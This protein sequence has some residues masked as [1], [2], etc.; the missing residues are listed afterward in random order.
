MAISEKDI[1][2]LWGRAAGRCSAPN[3]GEDLTPLLVKSGDVVLGE[4][5]HVIGRKLGAARANGKA[6][7]DSYENLILLCPTHHTLVD[8]AEDDYPITVLMSWKKDWEGIVGGLNL[9]IAS[10]IELLEEM[11]RCLALNHRIHSE[12]G[13]TSK[14]AMESPESTRAAATWTYRKINNILPNNRR[15]ALLLQANKQ[16]LTTEEWRIAVSFIE[17]ADFFE[18]HCVA[19]ADARAYL[20]FPHE[21]SNFVEKELERGQRQ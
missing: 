14:R 19:P 11:G 16:F 6:P 18:M 12:W 10:R 7:D 1:K 2:L 5:A 3:C 8:K 20:P 13:P 17:H 15:I 9:R 21:F 4:M